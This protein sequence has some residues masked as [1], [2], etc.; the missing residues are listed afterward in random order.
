MVVELC[1]RGRPR[2]VVGQELPGDFG[3]FCR[4]ADVE[5]CRVHVGVPASGL[6]LL[7]DAQQQTLTRRLQVVGEAR[8]DQFT[9]QGGRLRIAE[10]DGEERIGLQEGDKVGGVPDEPGRVQML[11][12]C[13]P[14]QAAY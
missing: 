7:T 12:G 11:A 8:D 4:I 1:L 5:E 6:A 2:G 3:E 14:G 9:Q 13:Q 10:V